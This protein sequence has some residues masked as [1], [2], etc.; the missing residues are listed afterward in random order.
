VHAHAITDLRTAPGELSFTAHIGDRAQHVWFRTNADLTANADAALAACLMPAM[1]AGGGRLELPEPISARLLRG[2]WEF[3]AVQRAWSRS[4][5]FGDPPLDEVEV[6]APRREP[7]DLVPRGT[8]AAF[9]SG[10]V[11]SWSTVLDH[12][13]VTHLIFARGFDLAAGES[14]LTDSVEQRL[15]AAA[16]ELGLPLITVETNLRELSDPIVR[17]DVYYGCAIVS[18]ALLL[19]PLFDRV[20]IAGDNDHEVQVPVGHN[21]RVGELLSTEGLQ[22]V[23]D[24]GR[25]SRFERLSRIVDHPVCQRTLRVCWENR[26]GAYN[27]GRCRKCLGTMISLEALGARERFTT[28]PP[29][30]DLAATEAIEIRQP[31]LLNLWLDTLDATR[32][33][34]RPDLERVVQRVVARGRAACGFAPDYRRRA[35]PGPPPTVRVGVVVPAYGQPQFLAAAVHSALE[36]RIDAGVGVVIVDDGCPFPSTREIA[37]ELCDAYPDHVVCLHQ[38]NRGV[39]AARNA[40]IE[41]AFARWPHIEAIFPLDADNLLSPET[42]DVLWQLLENHPEADWASPRLELMDAEQG[43]WYVPGRYLPYRQLFENQ[44]DAGSLIRRRVFDAAIAYDET[45]RDGYEDWEF[46]LHATL[47]GFTGI[48]A[49]EC[50]FRYRRRPHSM[51]AGAQEQADAIR[52]AVRAR[53]APAFAPRQLVRREHDEA[54]RFALVRVDRGDVLLTAAC[55]LEPRRVEWA[56]FARAVDDS[57]GGAWP[58]DELVPCITVLTTSAALDWLTERR[59]LPGML[60]RLQ[61][62]LRRHEV[63]G[64]T[65]GSDPNVT[66]G[67]RTRTVH[68]RGAE[69]LEADGVVEL[70]VDGH[71]P[72]LPADGLPGLGTGRFTGLPALPVPAH[73]Q[74]FA[75]LHIDELDTTLPWHGS[76]EGRDVLLVAPWL[77]SDGAHRGAVEL[78]RAAQALDASIALHLALTDDTDMRDVPLEVFETVTLGSP[79]RGFDVVVHAGAPVASPGALHVALDDEAARHLD[80]LVDVYLAPT[81]TAAQRLANLDAVP[82]KITLA[83]AA[84]VLRPDDPEHGRRLAADKNRRNGGPAVLFRGPTDLR[85]SLGMDV[86]EVV[87]AE[88]LERADVV[89][90]GQPVDPTL[91]LDAMAFGCLVI[92]VGQT[93]LDDIVVHGETGLVVEAGELTAALSDVAGHAR[94]RDA[95]VELALATS[96]EPAAQA[97]LGALEA[98]RSRREPAVAA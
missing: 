45:M 16:D 27:C 67:A 61:V 68:L 42:L 74:R 36:Q 13:D 37:A 26:D 8:V 28:F 15:R 7:R 71:V 24:G 91:A 5:V 55:D 20:L 3:Q 54:P 17:W 4:W 78:L 63:V 86:A 41:H 92:A 18:I 85:R 73:S 94:E 84:T 93:G 43:T 35:A 58:T 95:G 38:S 23:D 56:Q 76:G 34:G 40:G 77:R 9:F 46:F 65:L 80:G 25:Y 51:V 50:G 87:T 2:Q 44:C 96:W 29:D 33:A 60:L 10:G 89:V 53:H 47:A 22:I 81:Q 14:D 19:G 21:L 83:P 48:K 98:A 39:P 88:A 97:L 12:P 82:D 30:L 31:I 62:E 49:P 11:D 32:A 75:Q 79:A 57:G 72:P 1:R 69:D 64:V 52:E 66:L 6:V 70:H 59:L 90:L